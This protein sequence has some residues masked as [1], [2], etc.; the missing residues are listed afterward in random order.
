MIL[1]LFFSVCSVIL[2]PNYVEMETLDPSAKE[3][4]E[5]E[6]SSDGDTR[7]LCGQASRAES[8]SDSVSSLSSRKRSGI[9]SAEIDFSSEEG[10]ET[11]VNRKKVLKMRKRLKT[12]HSNIEKNRELS[13]SIPVDK[14]LTPKK[15]NLS[16]SSKSFFSF[17]ASK[18]LQSSTNETYFEVSVSSSTELP[19]PIAF[20]KLLR[21]EN[22]QNVSRLVRKS[23]FK[24][25]VRFG[26]NE[27]AQTLVNNSKFVELGYK[28]QMTFGGDV[29][30]SYGIIR[31]VDLELS[32]EDVMKVLECDSKITSVKRLRRVSEDG[33]WVPCESVRICFLSPTLPN[34][35]FAYGVRFKVWKNVFPVTQCRGCWKFG[36]FLKYC[37]IKKMTCPKCGGDHDNCDK[38]D[39]KCLNCK[40]N[41]FV[42]DK[43][44]PIFLKEK[45]IK[46]IMS[47]KNISYKRALQFYMQEDQNDD[48][49]ESVNTKKNVI[50]EGESSSFHNMGP[51]SSDIDTESEKSPI[52]CNKQKNVSVSKVPN[53]KISK[54]SFAAKVKM[55]KN[56]HSTTERYQPSQIISHPRVQ[57]KKEKHKD[58]IRKKDNDNDDKFSWK[59]LLLKLKEIYMCEQHLEFK[60]VSAVKLI[61]TECKKVLFSFMSYGDIFKGL[62]NLFNG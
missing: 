27:D 43:S 21:E 49:G 53:K 28:C 30:L 42:L 25:L 3:I 40:G 16:L 11:V 51:I 14:S 45:A 60:L 12:Q 34:H 4:I 54:D 61:F 15:D 22:I 35:V 59:R 58:E 23:D 50:T 5:V 24:V 62:L 2:V 26:S 46:D 6:M 18:S 55:S 52:L 17:A 9:V 38:S 39:F 57:E 29:S 56:K 7:I 1:K 13:F 48:K 31:G 20:A 36:H 41:H 44:C 47:S 19:K 33:K 32:D 37:P 8:M 10:Y